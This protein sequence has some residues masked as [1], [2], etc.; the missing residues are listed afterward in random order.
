M[1]FVVRPW[2][3]GLSIICNTWN[4]CFHTC[5]ALLNRRLWG[6]VPGVQASFCSMPQDFR[7][8]C[9]ERGSAVGS[10][11]FSHRWICE[12]PSGEVWPSKAGR[13][14]PTNSSP[15]IDVR[16]LGALC[17]NVRCIFRSL[18]VRLL[19]VSSQGRRMMVCASEFIISR[20]QNSRSKGW[21]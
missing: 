7:E 3:H 14:D 6:W 11:S 4:T 16:T 8:N 1:M 17:G 20:R 18:G 12:S 19:A 21:F 2:A 9:V 5:I 13:V 15:E 10:V